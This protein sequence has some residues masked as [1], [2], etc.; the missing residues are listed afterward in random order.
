L[1]QREDVTLFYA[2]R[3]L[4]GELPVSAGVRAAAYRMLADLPGVDFLGVVQDRQD[5]QGPSGMVVAFTRRGD[6]GWGQQRLIVEPRT[7]PAL[8]RESWFLGTG[9]TL[10]ATGTLM[11]WT[12]QVRAGYTDDAAPTA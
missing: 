4:V 11:S 1:P 8:A 2:G 6:G 5:R 9:A 3:D 10:A 12:V 7:G